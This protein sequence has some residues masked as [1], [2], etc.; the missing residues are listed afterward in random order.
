MNLLKETKDILRAYGKRV[1]D[2]TFVQGKD[3]GISVDKF[4][5]LANTTYNEGYGSQKV[6]EDLIIGGDDWW[7]ERHEY[8]GS[9]W[10]EYRTLPKVLPVKEDVYALTV[11]QSKVEFVG[12]KTLAELNVM[13][14]GEEE[15]WRG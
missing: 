11:N 10:W 9:E 3:F 6:A 2:I 15:S 12:W 7:L 13:E 1:K 14:A 8:D 5:K 4:L